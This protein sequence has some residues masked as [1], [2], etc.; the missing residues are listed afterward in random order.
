MKDSQVFADKISS[1]AREVIKD[2]ELKQSGVTPKD[3]EIKT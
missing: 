1:I 2:Q 3:E